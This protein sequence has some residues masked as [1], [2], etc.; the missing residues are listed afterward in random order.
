[1]A[2]GLS[3]S[4]KTGT[5][6]KTGDSPAVRGSRFF[7]GF[8]KL[9]QRKKLPDRAEF[10]PQAGTCGAM[11]RQTRLVSTRDLIGVAHDALRK[12]PGGTLAVA[13]N[14]RILGTLSISQ[15]DTALATTPPVMAGVMSLQPLMTLLDADPSSL[16]LGVPLVVRASDALSAVRTIFDGEREAAIVIVVA[17]D[18]RYIGTVLRSDL[19]A[20]DLGNLAPFRV[21]GMA[22]PLGVYLTDGIV[23]GGAGNLGLILTGVSITTLYLAATIVSTAGLTFLDHRY[24]FDLT[25][26]MA[27]QLMRMTPQSVRS[28]ADDCRG[29]I[30]FPLLLVF[31]RLVPISGYH[32]A[33]H[34]V[35]HCIE[36]GEPLLPQIVAKMPRGHPRC[37]TNIMAAVSIFSVA[38]SAMFVLS[39]SIV[40]SV[41]PALLITLALWRP[42]GTFLQEYLTTRPASQKQL[43]SGIIA[44]K[45]V[46]LRHLRGLER[47]SNLGLRIWNM[48]LV[49]ILIGSWIVLGLVELLCTKFPAAAKLIG[50]F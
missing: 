11:T 23:Q 4:E 15:L 1:M 28:L 46:M 18:D 43:E 44:G 26:W 49:Q 48:G 20:A 32:A 25:Q 9:R 30:A 19:V 24:H 14:G 2:L 8:N 22:T 37:G 29:L 40:Q 17:A 7:A 21:G 42:V 35:V 47:R 45:E 36:R 38:M 3:G 6:G 27:N 12:A 34:Q 39:N 10:D 50:P 13:E 31:L 16:T 33:E 5:D 41:V